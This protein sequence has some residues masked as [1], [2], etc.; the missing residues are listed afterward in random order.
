VHDFHVQPQT[1]EHF[2]QSFGVNFGFRRRV[3]FQ[4]TLKHLLLERTLQPQTAFAVAL[5][6]STSG[7][8]YGIRV[9]EA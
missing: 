1:A 7:M 8:V 2:G 5:V 3:L 9:V 4:R 6:P